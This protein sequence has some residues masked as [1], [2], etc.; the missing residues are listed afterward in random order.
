MNKYKL[1]VVLLSIL[2]PFET[3]LGST[4]IFNYALPNLF[5]SPLFAEKIRLNNDENASYYIVKK[6]DVSK[7][8]IEV[9]SVIFHKLSNRRV[10][11]YT[12]TSLHPTKEL[13][14][15]NNGTLSR[16]IE[17]KR[18]QH[19]LP[20]STITKDKNDHVDSIMKCKFEKQKKICTAYLPDGS[21]LGAKSFISEYENNILDKLIRNISDVITYTYL[22]SPN[23]GKWTKAIREENKKSRKS[24]AVMKFDQYGNKTKRL[25]YDSNNKMIQEGFY[26]NGLHLK[27]ISYKNNGTFSRT[28]SFNDA[29]QVQHTILAKDGQFICKFKFE[30]NKSGSVILTSA[31]NIKG[32][33]LAEYPNRLISYVNRDGSPQDKKKYSTYQK[34]NWW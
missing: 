28:S 7:R 24:T 34:D 18:N 32:E 4:E 19:G 8:I 11:E 10:F 29:R 17:Y 14:Y 15:D 6:D 16:V 30:R 9:S 12:G 5:A 3:A 26:K 1:F 2:L 21:I 33:L 31:Y 22:Y 13:K 20:I 25:V 27:D 23:I